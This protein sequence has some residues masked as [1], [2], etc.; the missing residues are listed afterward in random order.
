MDRKGPSPTIST[1]TRWGSFSIAPKKAVTVSVRPKAA[2]AVGYKSWRQRASSTVRVVTA[3]R[4]RT[5]PPA[6]KACTSRSPLPYPSIGADHLPRL[7]ALIRAHDAPHF[8]H[9]DEARGPGIPD[10]ETALQ[11]GNRRLPRLPHQ[12][13]RILKQLVLGVLIGVSPLGRR[14]QHFLNVLRLPLAAPRVGQRFHFLVRN[15]RPLGPDR[16]RRADGV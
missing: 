16:L 15:P 12:P 14:C 5:C 9:V 4:A 11:H 1:N 6:N 10:A 7:A 13:H 8:H 2:A 3:A